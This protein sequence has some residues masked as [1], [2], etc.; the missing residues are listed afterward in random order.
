MTDRTI[1]VSP[2]RG[3]RKVRRELAGSCSVMLSV[4]AGTASPSGVPGAVAVPVGAVFLPTVREPNTARTTSRSRGETTS[5]GG[6]IIVSDHEP[7]DQS[8]HEPQ[9]P[10]PEQPG[11]PS[12]VDAVHIP[13]PRSPLDDQADIPVPRPPDQQ[14]LN[15]PLNQLRRQEGAQS[16]NGLVEPEFRYD[17]TWKRGKRRHYSGFVER[18]GGADGERLREDLAAALRDLLDW[19]FQHTETLAEQDDDPGGGNDGNDGESY[20]GSGGDGDAR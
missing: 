15:Q 18:V 8:P 5:T 16:G 14:P 12:D 20:A 2:W 3:G 4:S 10:S 13:A 11:H 19:A 1:F 9:I 6:T 7:D 17:Q